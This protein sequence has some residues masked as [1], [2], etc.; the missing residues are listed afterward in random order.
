MVDVAWKARIYT[1]NSCFIVA[2]QKKN[3]MLYIIL[4][5]ISI[6]C[7]FYIIYPFV[8]KGSHIKEDKVLDFLKLRE[9]NILE[10]LNNDLESGALSEDMYKDLKKELKK[11]IK[12]EMKLLNNNIKKEDEIEKLIESRKRSKK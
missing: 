1:R 3:L 12:K 8:K 4:I 5:L 7:A 10:E 6:L 11:N 9:L 2:K